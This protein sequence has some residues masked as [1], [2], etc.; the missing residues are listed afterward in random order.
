M[1]T[2]FRMKQKVFYEF[3]ENTITMKTTLIALLTIAFLSSNLKAAERPD[4]TSIRP[5]K[6][7]IIAQNTPASIISDTTKIRIGKKDINIIDSPKKNSKHIYENS[8]KGNWRGFD[9]GFLSYTKNLYSNENSTDLKQPQSNQINLN[10]F[11][12][13]IGLQKQR[14]TLGI[15]SGFGLRMDN[16]KFENP[17]T[18]IKGTNGMEANR[19]DYTDLKKSKLF[20]GYLT[21][22]LLFE[23]HIPTD[24]SSHHISL[25][26][27]I[28]GNIR[29]SSHTK[30]K[31]GD[32][33]DKYRSDF[34]LRPFSYTETIRLGYKQYG[35]FVNYDHSYL[36]KDQYSPILRPI[37]FGFFF[38]PD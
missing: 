4:K 19:L 5:D 18:F 10:L 26:A 8:F 24:H 1:G 38:N 3:I 2:L 12:Y 6:V 30:V 14:N 36:I 13:S 31:Y 27:G 29:M 17:Y 23:I 11:Q 28:I 25:S 9:F 37:A 35:L 7:Q 20:V 21:V 34:N 22:P 33:K 16:Y 32:T 15:I